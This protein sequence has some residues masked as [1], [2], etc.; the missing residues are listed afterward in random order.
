MP[1]MNTADTKQS[2]L[3]STYAVTAMNMAKRVT[4]LHGRIVNLLMSKQ[5]V[6]IC[7]TV[8]GGN[9]IY[10]VEKIYAIGYLRNIRLS[11]R[12]RT[13]ATQ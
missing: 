13:L 12:R 4:T 5:S 6:N 11:R 10:V 2:A 1:S 9:E 3:C 7:T 8:F